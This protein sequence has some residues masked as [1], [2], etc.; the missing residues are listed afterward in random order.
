MSEGSGLEKIEKDLEDTF[1]RRLYEYSPKALHYITVG[2]LLTLISTGFNII[3]PLLL[4]YIMDEFAADIGHFEGSDT[5]FAAINTLVALCATS[6]IISTYKDRVI[7]KGSIELAETIRV[8]MFDKIRR[9]PYSRLIGV[10]TGDIANRIAN[11]CST[12]SNLAGS[13]AAT[14]VSSIALIVGSGAMMAYTN[15]ELA[16]VCTLPIVSAVLIT[17]FF[18]KS[19]DRYYKRQSKDLGEVNN[20]ILESF[21]GYLTIRASSSEG[22]FFKEFQELNLD[23]GKKMYKLMNYAS[24]IPSMMGFITNVG[25]VTICGYGLMMIADGRAT[26]G[27]IIGFLVYMR[28]FTQPISDISATA[29]ALKELQSASDRVFEV[30]D[31]REIQE[32]DIESIKEFKGGVEFDHVN[33]SFGEGKGYAIKDVSFKVEPGQTVAIIGPTGSGKTTLMN[34]LMGLFELESGTIKIDGTPIN[35]LNNVQMRSMFSLVAQ[36]SWVFKGTIRNNIV[37]NSAPKSD[38]YLWEVID[39]VG[40]GYIRKYSKGLDTYLDNP[41]ALSV[42]QKQ[43]LSVAR[44]II[45]DAP[46]LVLDEATSSVDIRTEKAIVEA[47]DKAAKKRTSFVIAHR[48]STIKSADLILVVENGTIHESGTMTELMKKGGLFYDLVSVQKNDTKTKKDP[49]PENLDIQ[50]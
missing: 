15:A 12:I 16:V 11:D 40:L 20:R 43:Q 8:D 28:L 22:K 45:H 47:L 48:L 31:Q 2:I 3:T 29:V 32:H 9:I 38:E 23:M 21:Y 5:I 33:F 1:M 19:L 35:E 34:L 41:S 26:F 27:L 7:S 37:Y 18:S 13:T 24:L 25:Y 6:F 14:G 42:G 4:S 39:S 36:N 49:M 10:R 50:S 30:L 46:I 44:A 17:L